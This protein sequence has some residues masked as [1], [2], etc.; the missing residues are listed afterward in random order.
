MIK[1]RHILKN[2]YKLK[3]SLSIEASITLQ[4]NAFTV[5][6]SI[7]GDLSTYH[8]PKITKQ[9]RAHE[10]WLDS[11]FELFI[12]KNKGTEYWEINLSPSTQWNCYHFTN[13]KENMNE[14]NLISTPSIIS[15]ND[16]NRYSLSFTSFIQNG[17]LSQELLINLCVILLDKN[18][19]RNFY[20]IKRREGTP[21]FHDREYFS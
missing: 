1:Q 19:I 11:T 12:A 3:E 14:S 15:Y 18:G 5:E 13:Y 8:F 10:L 7:I 4:N 17:L 20:S 9:E 6:Y 16:K 21:D 2:H